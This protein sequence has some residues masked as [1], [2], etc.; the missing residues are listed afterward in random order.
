M[1]VIAIFGGTGFIGCELVKQ[2][3]KMPVEIRLF[4]R[5]K[6]FYELSHY[7]NRNQAHHRISLFGFTSGINLLDDLK[8]TDVIINLVGILHESRSIKFSIA[9]EDYVTKLVNSALKL[10]IKR[11]IHI[12]ALGVNKIPSSK[13]LDSKYK[14]ELIIKNKF[15]GH[16]WTILRPSIVFGPHDKFINLFKK[17]VRFLPLIFLISPK[18]EFQPI[19]VDDLVD[20]MIKSIDD[21]KTYKKVFNLGGPKK[22]TF[23]EIIKL[24]TICDKKRNIVI[25]LNKTMSYL[26]V[27]LLQLSPIK[28][29]TTDNLKSM[30]TSNTVKVN[31]AYNFK[32][33]L[34][35]LP[36]YLIN[37]KQH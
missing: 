9:H 30:E 31:D 1:K 25:G 2:L 28:I 4:V 24:I 32:S 26:F 15:K 7:L 23:Y 12:S 37:Y 33:S 20:I 3:H 19:H 22:F 27:R 34:K 16:K 14:T 35:E 29:I 11:M 36:T 17:M 8:G 21:K 5:K 10:K 13:Y 18:A 6:N